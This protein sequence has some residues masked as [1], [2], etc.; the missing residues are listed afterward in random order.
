MIV[1]E[2]FPNVWVS[3]INFVLNICFW[4]YPFCVSHTQLPGPNVSPNIRKYLPRRLLSVSNCGSFGA[5]DYCELGSRFKAQHVK[6]MVWWTA[7]KV[8][9]LTS[10]SDAHFEKSFWF[11]G[12][13]LTLPDP[14]LYFPYPLHPQLQWS[15]ISG[16][17][18][19]SSDACLR[20]FLGKGH[21]DDWSR[22]LDL[23]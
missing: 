6:V 20:P 10:G 17:S 21:G 15:S 18:C 22:W 19:T 4:I 16:W 1:F 7:Y 11:F 13:V 8:G 3:F 2:A 14:G 12:V 9:K 5:D 23:E